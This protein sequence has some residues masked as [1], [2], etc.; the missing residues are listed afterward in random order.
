MYESAEIQTAEK[1]L[2]KI[3][4]LVKGNACLLGGWAAY[5]TVN[6]N[7][8][9]ATGRNYIGSRDI[10]IGFHIDKNL[11]EEQLRKSEFC[12]ALKQIENMGFQPISFRLAKD[13]TLETG[14]ELTPGESA[15]LQQYEILR[16]YVDLIVDYIHPKIKPTLGFV[17]I[18]EPLLSLVFT[19][20]LS[21][22]TKLFGI[23]ILMPQTHVLL[24]MKLNSVINRDKEDKRIKDIADIYALLWHSNTKISQLK[25]QLYFIYAPEKARKTSQA[26]TKTE[27][28][29]VSTIIGV[30]AHEI[31]RAITELR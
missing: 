19:K 5:H 12:N 7:F 28:K 17:P 6:Q 1:Y 14:K 30:D 27:I 2:Q 21:I 25:N 29:K 4:K 10:D 22:T 26:F 31:S 11:S 13:F 3:F 20:K 23:N 9:K 16:L 24:A 8:E 18:D 15:R